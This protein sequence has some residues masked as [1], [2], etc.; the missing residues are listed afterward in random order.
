MPPCGLSL[1]YINFTATT[2]DHYEFS[3]KDSER[4]L[5][6]KE[7]C[8]HQNCKWFLF[9]PALNLNVRMKSQSVP[10]NKVTENYSALHFGEGL[11]W[12]DMVQLWYINTGYTSVC[13]SSHTYRG[14]WW[15]RG[16]WQR[17]LLCWG[18]VSYSELRVYTAP[19]C[20]HGHRY[21]PSQ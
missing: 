20:L 2:S 13:I 9:A 5:R 17:G 10:V 6:G 4:C 14:V 19:C 1:N 21:K 11:R 16:G 3:C 15:H 8:L 7:L 12:Y 18:Q